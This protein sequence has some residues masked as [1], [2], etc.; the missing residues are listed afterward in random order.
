MG[1]LLLIN[2]INIVA[3]ANLSSSVNRN[4]IKKDQTLTLTVRYDGQ[5]NDNELDLSELKENFN[6]LAVVPHTNY[7][8]STI[9]GKSTQQT[10][11]TWSITLA[12]EK[13][14]TFTIPKF[15]I[16]NDSSQSISIQVNALTA[17]DAAPK[18]IE[19]SLSILESGN[20]NI[21]LGEQILITTILSVTSDVNDLRGEEFTLDGAD[22]ELIDQQEGQHT[23]NGISRQAVIWKYAIFPT[24]SGQITIPEQTFTGII[25]GRSSFFRSTVGGQR[26]AG[27]TIEQS[28]TVEPQPNTNGKPWFPANN[29]S[30]ESTW[31]G[32]STKIRVGEP[33]TRNITITAVGQRANVI[34]PLSAQNDDSKYK[35][36]QD[37]PQLE[38]TASDAGITGKRTES[39]A[40]IPSKIGELTLPEQRIS[41]WD[42]N[43]DEWRDA[44]LPAET[45]TVLPSLNPVNNNSSNNQSIDDLVYQQTKDSSVSDTATNTSNLF[46]KLATLILMLICGLQFFLL[47]RQKSQPR[48][49]ESVNKQP[50]ASEKAEW[51]ELQQDMTTGDAKKIR[52]Q[53]LRWAQTALP[54]R[55]ITNLDS[56]IE[57]VEN[58]EQ[59]NELKLQINTLE[60]HIYNNGKEINLDE[61]SQTINKLK[62]S[63]TD[64]KTTSSKSET[65]KALYPA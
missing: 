8:S 42:N 1:L 34:P 30:V 57:L 24:S 18:A 26:V 65:L 27:K 49:K 45:L 2:T 46:W 56:L 51:R 37:Q 61:F 54:E 10:I 29:V 16:N 22:I 14:G 52:S 33:I 6:V 5:I 28:I 39:V 7:Y 23:E 20:S 48:I 9:N 60:R 47:N 38:N 11:T 15:T 35:S 25:G 50:Q 53:L 58:S 41:W 19:T 62:D 4:V 3:A 31:A 21:K 36:Y 55:K 64:F 44:V 59:K 63:V 12:A 13:E 40:I 32:D 17:A 43:A